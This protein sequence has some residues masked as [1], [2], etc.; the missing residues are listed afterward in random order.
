MYGVALRGL[1]L[2]G[3]ADFAMMS[4]LCFIW[5]SILQY[6]QLQPFVFFL[7]VF[8]LKLANVY[9]ETTVVCVEQQLRLCREIKRRREG[10]KLNVF[11]TVLFKNKRKNSHMCMKLTQRASPD[12]WAGDFSLRAKPYK[13]PHTEITLKTV[14]W[15]GASWTG[16]L[17]NAIIYPSEIP[18]T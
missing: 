16:R 9:T 15:D 14:S 8:H 3:L 1:S 7:I 6:L 13:Q 2:F 18:S 10:K 12:K 17:V 4:S 11:G 5:K